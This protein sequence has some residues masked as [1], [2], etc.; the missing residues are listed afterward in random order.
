MTNY[1]LFRRTIPLGNNQ[2]FGWQTPYEQAI[3]QG[4]RRLIMNAINY[5]NLLYLSEKLRQAAV[6]RSERNCC[7]TWKPYCNL[8]CLKAFVADNEPL[9]IMRIYVI[10]LSRRIAPAAGLQNRA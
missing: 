10:K 7:S 3:A 2:A 9:L 5:H 6:Y 4:C 1:V 8:I